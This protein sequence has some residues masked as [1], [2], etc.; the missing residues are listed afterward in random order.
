M[1][2]TIFETHVPTNK[3]EGLINAAANGNLTVVM[4]ICKSQQCGVNDKHE[5]QTA[6]HLACQN[7]HLDVIKY[8]L[9]QGAQLEIEVCLFKFHIKPGEY[10][11]FNP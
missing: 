4:E 3:V 8:L 5:G 6:L 11:I 10:G 9:S 7:G 2:R 1:L